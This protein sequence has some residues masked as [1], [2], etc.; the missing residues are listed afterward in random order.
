MPGCSGAVP[1]WLSHNHDWPLLPEWLLQAPVAGEA[2]SS[3]GLLELTMESYL[4]QVPAGQKR[5]FTTASFEYNY[6]G[7][8]YIIKMPIVIE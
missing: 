8:N 4:E 2:K 3:D 1:P 5:V 7:P 6:R